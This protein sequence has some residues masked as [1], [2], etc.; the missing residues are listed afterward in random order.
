MTA[1]T[2][3]QSPRRRRKSSLSDDPVRVATNSSVY[4]LSEN[5]TFS[6]VPDFFRICPEKERQIFYVKSF[7]PPKH[8]PRTD[9]VGYQNSGEREG[10]KIPLALLY[11]SRLNEGL[12]YNGFG[13][14]RGSLFRSRESVIKGKRAPSR[15]TQKSLIMTRDRHII[16]I[17]RG[18]I[19]CL[20]CFHGIGGLWL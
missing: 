18:G 15:A 6:S 11:Y 8:A 1:S 7:S 17:K 10:I 12:T 9:I 4:S 3:G 20:L 2:S 19:I 13:G 5:M 16:K 14:N